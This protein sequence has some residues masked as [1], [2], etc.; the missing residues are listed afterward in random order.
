MYIDSL[1]IL[2]GTQVHSRLK[3]NF[4]GI[5][6]MEMLFKIKTMYLEDCP[7]HV[8]RIELIHGHVV[9]IFNNSFVKWRYS[10][11]RPVHNMSYENLREIDPHISSKLNIGLI[12]SIWNV[13][14][15][16]TWTNPIFGVFGIFFICLY[17]SFCR[18]HY[19]NGG[20]SQHIT[21]R[22]AWSF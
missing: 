19:R 2:V 16:L 20:Y 10:I 4:P 18:D 12:L 22:K 7:W 21:N 1:S 17:F 8:V 11:Y 13:F 6:N 9:Y 3:I 5:M 15:F 14:F